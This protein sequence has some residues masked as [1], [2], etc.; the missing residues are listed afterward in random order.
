MISA[1]PK[2]TLAES[3]DIWA[4]WRMSVDCQD[5]QDEAPQAPPHCVPPAGVHLHPS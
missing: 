2:A 3:Q 4:F 1:F 5:C